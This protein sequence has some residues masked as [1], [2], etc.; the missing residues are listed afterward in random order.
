MD[1]VAPDHVRVHRVV[2]GLLL[3]D[4]RML[5]CHRSADRTWYP[6]VWDLP[7]GHIEPG[8]SPPAALARELQE[9]LGIVMP[10]PAGPELARL[11]ASDVDCRIWVVREW[12][13][14]PRI[15]PPEHDALG[16]WLPESLDDLRLAD[17]A[18]KELARQALAA[19][20]PALT[21]R[22]RGTA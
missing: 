9:E 16:W 2:A 22:P 7:G 21:Q 19:G 3:R 18:Y 15:V 10:E 1:D 4:G 13:G 14:T 8:E 12:E 11:E 17:E 5:L 6:D 20:G